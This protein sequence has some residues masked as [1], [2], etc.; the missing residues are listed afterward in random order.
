MKKETQTPKLQQLKPTHLDA[1]AFLVLKLPQENK[2][3]EQKINKGQ[4]Q[5]EQQK[6]YQC[7]TCNKTYQENKSLATHRANKPACKIIWKQEYDT[8]RTC[9]NTERNEKFSTVEKCKNA[10]YTTAK[11][12]NK[13]LN[14]TTIGKKDRRTIQGRGA[15]QENEQ[16][17][18]GKSHITQK[19]TNGYA[20]HVE[21]YDPQGQQN[22]IQHACRHFA[23]K[24]TSTKM[25]T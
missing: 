24:T 20:T 1:C 9:Q 14:S 10:H 7:K 13:L 15:P 11:N 12:T 19:S 23:H 3:N 8:L 4:E 25:E 21:K 22:A 17:Y 18:Q 2:Q 6:T 16:I 5:Q